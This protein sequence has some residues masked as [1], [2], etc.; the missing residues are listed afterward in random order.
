MKDVILQ[1]DVR[2]RIKEIP[3][4]HVQCL[5][6]SPPYFAL[7][8]YGV[9]GQIGLEASIDE[10]IEE[11][12]KV[13][14]QCK[15][16]L[17]DDGTMWLNIGDTY[18][19][20]GGNRK[21]LYDSK[22][23]FRTIECHAPI[24]R[25]QRSVDLK[26]DGYKRKDLL[27]IPWKLAE[28]LRKD[29]WYLRSEI[30]WYKPNCMPEGVCDRPT[31]AHETIFLFAKTEKYIYDKEAIKEKAV[32]NSE[33]RKSF[34]G[35]GVYTENRSM[36]NKVDIMN[37]TRGNKDSD[38]LRNSRTY[39]QTEKGSYK[40]DLTE[41]LQIFVEKQ[42]EEHDSDTVDIWTIAT[43]QLRNAHH[44]TFPKELA[45]RCINAGSRK[46]DIVFDPFM[47]LGTVA[48]VA[49]ERQRY[50]LGIELDA[51]NVAAANER[52][53]GGQLEMII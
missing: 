45:R 37:K 33:N 36:Q 52:I 24:D 8:D 18:F 5:V 32:Q 20:S 40:K 1:G 7:R 48:V 49:A 46:G 50:Y 10:F 53:K 16:I 23:I 41:M 30:I 2:N 11:L 35:G 27:G 15:R 3:D 12:V 51:D 14:R 4:K 47:G 22:N 42:I 17:K 43:S 21:P 39:W 26:E 44:A 19:P 13:F 38:G 34:R 9:T 28:A 6:S 31:K 29:G 25:Y